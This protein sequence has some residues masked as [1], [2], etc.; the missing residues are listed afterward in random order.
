LLYRKEG[1]ASRIAIDYKDIKT[2]H[3]DIIPANR[4]S[5]E[6]RKLVIETKSHGDIKIPDGF[7]V[8]L[9]EIQ[10]HIFGKIL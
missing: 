9:S 3:I 1:R 5:S 2:S 8:E 4:Y 10:G 7:N 6:T